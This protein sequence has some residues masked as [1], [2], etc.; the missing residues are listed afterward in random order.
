MPTAATRF[1]RPMSTRNVPATTVPISPR[2]CARWESSFW[3]TPATE[4]TPATSS[5]LAAKTTED[6]RFSVYVL[7]PLGMARL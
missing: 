3:T 5:R 1:I 7:E 2:V 4:R 6:A